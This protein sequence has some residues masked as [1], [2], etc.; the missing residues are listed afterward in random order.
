MI[1]ADNGSYRVHVSEAVAH[2]LRRLQGRAVS[3]G[4]GKAFASAW[5][6][7]VRAL[8]KQPHSTGEALYELPKL[9]LQIRLVIAGPLA[10]H[11]AVSKDHPHVYIKSGAYLVGRGF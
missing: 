6:R 4:Q 11:F 8:R 10:I 2:E 1:D 9:R 7:I 5:S 3:Q